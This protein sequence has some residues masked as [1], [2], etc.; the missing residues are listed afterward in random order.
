MMSEVINDYS[1]GGYVKIILLLTLIM[2]ATCWGQPMNQMSNKEKVEYTFQ[3]LDKNS[4]HLV[5]EFYHEDIEFHDPVGTVKGRRKMKAYYENMYQNAKSVE[6]DF[7]NFVESGDMI[8]GVWKM[9]L[10]TDKLNGGGPI[11]VDGNSVIRFKDGKAI[12]HRD[13]FDMGAFIYENIPVLGFLVKK[14]K[15]RFKVNE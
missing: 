4:M 11:V 14:I 3:K 9:T 7:T 10:V 1:L 12:Y 5:D 6:F 8:V 15:E 2:S 13:Y